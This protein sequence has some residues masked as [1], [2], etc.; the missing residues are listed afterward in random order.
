VEVEPH[1][2]DYRRTTIQLP[3]DAPIATST[4]H[5]ITAQHPFSQPQD[6]ET[7]R[8]NNGALR[9]ALLAAGAV[10][11]PA[12]AGAADWWE[13]SFWVEGIDRDQAVALG[14]RFE[15]H[16]VFEIAEGRVR[17]IGCTTGEVLADDPLVVERR[18]DHLAV[19]ASMT[20][21]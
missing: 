8:K 12:R 1:L 13:D 10:V 20:G 11:V 17:V 4:A 6:A 2:D 15:Q 21:H 5:V 14:R 3:T 16:A 7:N 18:S 9:E 19:H